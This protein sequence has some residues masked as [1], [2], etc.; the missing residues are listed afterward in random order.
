MP[1]TTAAASYEVTRHY[2]GSNGL[3]P[4]ETSV[5]LAHLEFRLDLVPAFTS[6]L[7]LHYK[8]SRCLSL[9]WCIQTMTAI[10]QL[11]SGAWTISQFFISWSG[12][13]SLAYG[14]AHPQFHYHELES[15]MCAELWQMCPPAGQLAVDL[16]PQLLI[17][18][19]FPSFCVTAGSDVPQLLWEWRGAGNGHICIDDSVLLVSY[20]YAGLFANARFFN[21]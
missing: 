6:L 8:K 11:H 17:T 19:S 16:W 3:E 2:V 12:I 9:K 5:L 4:H 7:V 15:V 1:M 10:W 18:Q 21:V 14:F 13:H 20:I